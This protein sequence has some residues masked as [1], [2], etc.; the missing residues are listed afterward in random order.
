MVSV[1][2]QQCIRTAEIISAFKIK[3]EFYNRSFITVR[4]NKERKLR[5]YFYVVA[6]CHQTYNLANK[7]RNLYGWDY[8]EEVFYELLKEESEFFNRGFLVS[9]S[10]KEIESFIRPLFSA[11]RNTANCTLDNLDERIKFLKEIDLF[12]EE[13]Y[14]GNILTLTGK[15]GYKLINS[16]K[17]FYEIL[18]KL[19]SFSDPYK[20]KIS[21]LVKLLEDADLIKI[22]D[23]EN[24]IPI[25][26]YHMQRVLLR[27]GCV[28]V[29]DKDLYE[30][31]I[32]KKELSSDELIRNE[33]INAIKIIA[34]KS[35]YSIASMNDFFWP[36]GRSCCNSVPL[37]VSGKCEKQPCSLSF[38]IDIEPY[39][40][41][42]IFDSICKGRN[43]EHYR[44][45]WQ[46][47]VNTHY[48]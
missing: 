7:D 29:N 36:H 19:E 26:D 23:P 3:K 40:K 18:S 5:A 33:C 10:T 14:S 9:R 21:F 35:G 24:Y 43:D 11:D 13:K 32:N 2:E 6:I 47:V 46:P 39:H 31:L 45:L 1:N 44:R 48:Y 42:C 37:C 12:L 8:L 27:L 28:D 41:Y 17:G 34:D 25:M 20:K 16:G 38:A 22:N 15:T 4:T 30:D